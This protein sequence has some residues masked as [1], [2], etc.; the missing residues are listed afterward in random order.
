MIPRILNNT[1]RNKLFKGKA[2]I[3]IGPHQTG[4]TTLVNS[5]ISEYANDS[6]ILNCDDPM[7]KDSLTGASLATLKQIAGSKKILFID[8]AQRV[9]NIGLTLKLIHDNIDI[10][11]IVSGSSALDIASKINESLTGRKW[12]YRLFPFSYKELFD[13]YGFIDMKSQL[14]NRLIYGM[15]PDVINHPGEEKQVLNELAGSYLYKDVLEMD[16]VRKPELLSKILVAISLQLGSEVSYNEISNLVQT[17]K[18]TVI[19]YI[20]LLEKAFIIFRL[21]SFR[22]N[23]RSEIS[24]KRKIFFYDNGI[25]NAVISNFSNLNFRTDTGALWENFLVSVRLKRNLYSFDYCNSYFWR[26]VDQKEIDYIEEK[27]GKLY[28]YEFKWNSKKKVKIPKSFN[29]NYPDASF[30]VISPENYDS[31]LME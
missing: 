12:E 27:N 17:D 9:E 6:L 8:E 11:L 13:Y 18:N 19:K 15:Y 5:I 2:L 1:L 16:G 14:E 23:M 24:S 20:D 31:F 29:I 7:V 25:R 28:A 3:V 26:T 21:S 4:K 22:R 10:Q 30:E